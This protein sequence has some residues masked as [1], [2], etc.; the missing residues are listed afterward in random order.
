MD[1]EKT[2]T[3]MIKFRRRIFAMSE[4]DYQ[5]PKHIIDFKK[6]IKYSIEKATKEVNN[7]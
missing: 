4:F 1:K 2:Y 7:C 3:Q 5:L 6:K